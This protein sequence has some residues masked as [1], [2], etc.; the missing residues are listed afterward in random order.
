MRTIV[1]VFS[2]LTLLTFN[3]YSQN[4]DVKGLLDKPETRTEIF[5]AIVGDH[6]LMMKFLEVVKENEHASMMMH[7]ENNPMNKMESKE[8]MSEMSGNQQLMDHS[9]MMSMMKDNP[10]M[11]QK[12]MVNMMDMSDRDST[13]RGKM[14]D[15]MIQHSQLMQMCMQEMIEKGMIGPDG[16]MKMMN[17][18][19]QSEKEE[20][21][22]NH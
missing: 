11:M 19:V 13:I 5:N 20:H 9:E 18:K 12:M 10:E 8:W 3:G 15:M 14:A 6:E 16:K 17:S 21:N 22:R 4:V 7:D 2:M 1:I